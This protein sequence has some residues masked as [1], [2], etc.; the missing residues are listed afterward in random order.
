[1]TDLALVVHRFTEY[2]LAVRRCW[3]SDLEF[4]AVCEDYATATCAVERWKTDE[5]KAAHY[6]KIIEELEDEIQEYL[7]MPQRKTGERNAR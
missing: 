6:R 5:A 3:A 1:M 7:E 4:R 2:E